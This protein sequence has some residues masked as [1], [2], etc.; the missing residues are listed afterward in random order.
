MKTN[1][2]AD[3]AMFIDHQAA[4]DVTAGALAEAHTWEGLRDA[5]ARSID[6][7]C[8]PLTYGQ[9][10]SAGGIGLTTGCPALD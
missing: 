5:L 7:G 8:L 3:R 10:V 4:L 2:Q 9:Y 1:N 6:S